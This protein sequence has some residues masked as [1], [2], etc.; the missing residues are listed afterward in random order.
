MIKSVSTTSLTE[1]L[2]QSNIESSPAWELINGE[3]VQKSMP[4]LINSR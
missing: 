4:T 1:F 2:A 3:A